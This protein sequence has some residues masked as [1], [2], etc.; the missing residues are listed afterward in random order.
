MMA[1]RFALPLLLAALPL[2]AAAG[3][4]VIKAAKV[5]TAAGPPLAPGM[6]RVAGGKIA[7]VAERI[8]P[9]LGAEVID[10]G[11]GT[12]MPGLVDAHNTIGLESE[13]SEV[14]AEVTPNFRVLDEVDWSARGFRAA[15]TEGVTAV[16]L[17]PGTDNVIAG[18]ASV[19]KTAGEPAQRVVRKDHALVI[20]LAMDP[21]NRNGARNRPDSI[22][23]RQPTNR[24]GVV[25]MLRSEFGRARQSAGK[26]AAALRDALDGKRTVVCVSRIDSDILSALRLRQEYPV[27][28]TLAGAQEAYKVKGELAAAKVP[29]LLSPLPTTAAGTGPEGSETVWNQ[30]GVLHA[31]SIPFALTGDHLLEQARF[32]V[33]YGLP[34]D[35][36]LAAV[37]AAPAKLLG[38]ADRVGTIAAGKDADLVALTGDPFDFTAAVRWT[39]TDG[40]IRSRER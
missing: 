5:Y 18:L 30:P 40:V 26:D 22:Y 15:A 34:P 10:L 14:T 13:S 28:L 2:P 27:Q 29:V 25:W 24:M 36:A 23:N 37:T 8:T 19:V 11:A 17:V 38:V 31:A 39:M 12:L 16:G 1:H 3:E 21:S 32:A 6:V 9:P 35:A 4:I 33:R 7:E 20:T